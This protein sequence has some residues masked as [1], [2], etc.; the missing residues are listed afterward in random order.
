MHRPVNVTV[1]I[2]IGAPKMNGGAKN[3][4]ERKA[5]RPKTPS[6]PEFQAGQR[7]REKCQP[8]APAGKCSAPLGPQ[9]QHLLVRAV[10]FDT[11][12]LHVGVFAERVMHDAAVEGI[13]RLQFHR[14]APA[15]DFVGPTMKLPSRRKLRLMVSGVTK[16][17]VGLGWKWFSAVRRKPKPFSEISR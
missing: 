3:T 9:D 14:V 1:H 5:G 11:V 17:S 15:A 12:R 7:R 10:H 13:E 16:M 8:P 4:V 2:D 6:Q